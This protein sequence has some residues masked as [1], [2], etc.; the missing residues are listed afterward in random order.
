MDE[1]LTQAKRGV[2][3]LL[4]STVVLLA[5][6]VVLLWSAVYGLTFVLP[7]WAAALIVGGGVVVIGAVLMGGGVSALRVEK[8]APRQT[9]Q[10]LRT[11]QRFAQE[12]LS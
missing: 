11:D 2:I 8:L 3:S 1:K 10:S 7:L 5:G 12:Q 6:L 9:V 4:A